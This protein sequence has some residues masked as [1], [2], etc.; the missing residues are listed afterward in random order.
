MKVLK[1]QIEQALFVANELSKYIYIYIY[2]YIH[3]HIYIYIIH[4]YIYELFQ[5][6]LKQLTRVV[7]MKNYYF[8]SLTQQATI[9]T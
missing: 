9:L 7:S 3:T 8:K 6:T 1:V 2:I 5:L 4:I